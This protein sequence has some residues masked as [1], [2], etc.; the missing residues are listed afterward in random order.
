MNAFQKA[1]GQEK[2]PPALL[3]QL[4][5]CDAHLYMEPDFFRELIG[6]AG[7]GHVLDYMTK[8][9][10]TEEDKAARERAKTE[11][12]KV[13]GLSAL[14]AADAGD[15]L[16]AMDAMGVRGQLLF[17]QTSGRE[18]RMRT[19]EARAA[20]SRYNDFAIEWSRS[21]GDRARAACQVNMSDVA[22]SMAELDRILKK[23]ARAVVLP[24]SR[25]P[26]GVSPANEIWD[27]FW[28]RLEE[29]NVPALLH[30][31]GGGLVS[32]ATDDDPMFPSHEFARGKAMQAKFV[33][34]PGGEEAIGPFFFMVAHIAPEVWLVSMVMGGVFERFP[35]LRFGAIEFG[36]AWVGPMCERMEQHADLLARIGHAYPLRPSEYLRRN[37]RV[38]PFWQEDVDLMIQRHGLREVFTFSSDYPHIEGTRDPI[39]KF[40]AAMKNA[41]EAYL[42]DFF[43]DNAKLL[44]PGI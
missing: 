26:A 28:A 33:D 13:K 23:G 16:V 29:A 17:P 37:V 24:C 19:A 10:G 35:K 25:A 7:G 12:W 9:S 42:R 8:F 34:R 21:T 6:P 11:V 32:G 27:P 22:W 36:A 2:L 31:G 18:L 5:D 44:F 38:T 15:R 20:C 43:V 14:G 41:D 3:G 40:L 39:G 1:P 4:L 30:I